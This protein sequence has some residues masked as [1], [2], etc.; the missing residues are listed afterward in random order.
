[1]T[2]CTTLRNVLS[3]LSALL[4]FLSIAACEADDAINTSV[5][6]GANITLPV[7]SNDV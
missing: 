7:G 5:P 4:L 1:M 3:S 6:T 2:T